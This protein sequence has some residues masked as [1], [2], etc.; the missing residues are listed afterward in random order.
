MNE[1]EEL[2]VV[3][4]ILEDEY[5]DEVELELLIESWPEVVFVALEVWVEIGTNVLEELD[6]VSGVIVE[7]NSDDPE[8]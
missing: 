3:I 8:L 7:V 1:S 4:G 2:T 6:G 5:S